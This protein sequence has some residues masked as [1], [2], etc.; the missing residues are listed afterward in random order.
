MSDSSSAPGAE[1]GLPLHLDGV[2]HVQPLGR[3]RRAWNTSSWTQAS[4]SRSVRRSTVSRAAAG[5]P[6]SRR[7]ATVS[8]Q[9]TVVGVDA[10]RAGRPRRSTGTVTPACA[11]AAGLGAGVGPAPPRASPCRA[12]RACSRRSAH[13]V[14]PVT[15]SFRCFIETSVSLPTSRR[16]RKPRRATVH[17]AGNDGR[18]ARRRY[19]RPDAERPPD[20]GIRRRRTGRPRADA[21]AGASGD[22]TD[23]ILAAASRLF[24]ELGVDGTTMSRIAAEVGLKQSSLYYYFRSKEEVVAALVARAN[25]VPARADRRASPPTAAPAPAQLYR[26]VRGDVEALCA[27]PFDINEIHRIAAR[28]RERFADYWNER[29]AARAP[30]RRA[31]SAAASTTATLRDGRAPPHGA[32][33]H[34]QRRGRA[35]LVPPRAPSAAR[36]TIGRAT[37]PTWSSAACS[38]TRRRLDGRCRAEADDRRGAGD[39]ASAEPPSF[40][41]SIETVTPRSRPRKRRAKQRRPYVRDRRA[42]SGRRLRSA[43]STDVSHDGR[44]PLV[45]RFT[46]DRRPGRWPPRCSASPAA[47]TTTTPADAAGPTT[48]RPSGDDQLTIGYSAWPGWFPLA[49]AEEQ[50]IFEEVGL[51][52]ELDVLRR[53]HR[54]ARRPGRR[55]GRRQR[56]DAQRHDLRRRRRAPS[57]RSSSST[58][59]PPATTQIIC[60]ESITSVDGPARARRSPPRPASSTTSCCSRAW[61][62]RA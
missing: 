26:F 46:A 6:R 19:D 11:A 10:R 38:P 61:P 13:R 55:P 44:A 14:L 62:R 40:D 12:R 31:S 18:R 43:R 32:H 25:V 33:D 30:A 29:R 16:R 27:L 9:I 51:D 42:S 47:A 20:R 8:S 52:V 56:P 5:A 49:V 36:P 57:R 50:G 35:E 24:G 1:V 58:T 28:D 17:D 2:G 41:S 54:L 7:A 59:T 60:D 15:A 39:A 48:P 34:G 21:P 22:P 53:L 23:E 3:C 4:P 37:W 45:R